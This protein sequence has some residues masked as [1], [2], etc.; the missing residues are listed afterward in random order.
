MWEAEQRAHRLHDASQLARLDGA[1]LHGAASPEYRSTG[2]QADAQVRA[3]LELLAI[4]D[5]D[6]LLRTRSDAFPQKKL[7]WASVA[8]VVASSL[9]HALL[10]GGDLD[11]TLEDC[12][13][14]ARR[15]EARDGTKSARVTAELRASIDLVTKC[16][17][18]VALLRRVVD[19]EASDRDGMVVST[20]RALWR[21]LSDAYGGDGAWL[22]DVVQRAS[23]RVLASET[24]TGLTKSLFARAAAQWSPPPPV[25]LEPSPKRTKGTKGGQSRTKTPG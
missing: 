19:G 11:G 20:L 2:R 1:P 22:T 16:A 24:A 8:Q 3:G 14:L 10:E 7:T 6:A 17:R 18:A 9:G 4:N 25:D 23:G 12:E 5:Y 15:L 21:R 13:L